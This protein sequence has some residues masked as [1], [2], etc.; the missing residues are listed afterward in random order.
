[1][2]KRVLPMATKTGK[3]TYIVEKYDEKYDEKKKS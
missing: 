2:L 1:M 3:G